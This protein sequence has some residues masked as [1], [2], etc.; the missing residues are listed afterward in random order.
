MVKQAAFTHQHLLSIMAE[1]SVNTCHFV[2]ALHTE[3]FETL[4]QKKFFAH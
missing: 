1:A 3:L 2:C 4:A